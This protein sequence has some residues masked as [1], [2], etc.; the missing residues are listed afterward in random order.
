MLYSKDRKLGFRKS[1]GR[2]KVDVC[3]VLHCI[4]CLKPYGTSSSSSTHHL[5]PRFANMRFIFLR[6][7]MFSASLFF[8]KF[9]CLS[10]ILEIPEATQAAA[11]AP[12]DLALGHTNWADRRED[13]YLCPKAASAYF[14]SLSCTYTYP[15]P[16]DVC[17]IYALL[18]RVSLT[19][20]HVLDQQAKDETILIKYE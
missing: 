4:T 14:S 18:E 11:V 2:S 5:W 15:H 7:K 3:S 1:S 13:L 10:S 20:Q 12:E 16:K 8:L 17:I 6:A 19:L 9:F